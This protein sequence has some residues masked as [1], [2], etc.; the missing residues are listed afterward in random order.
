MAAAHLFDPNAAARAF[1]Q[2][3]TPIRG[4]LPVSFF[5]ALLPLIAVLLV[6]GGLR[7]PSWQAALAGLVV[8]L[9]I[10]IGVW[11]FPP[12][13]ALAAVANGAM[14]AIWPLLWVVFNAILLY[15]VTVKS[16]S[17][18]ALKEWVIDHLPDDRRIVLVVVGFCFGALLE[19]IAGFG[20]PVAITS[21]LLILA[22]FAPLEAIVC[23]LIFN[24][25]PV[26]F[27]ALGVPITVLAA[28][29]HL[30]PSSL[31]A[32]VG[33]QLPLFALILPFYGVGVYAGRR[34]IRVLWPVLLVAGGTFGLAQ[35]ACANFISY[36]LTDVLASLTSLVA[37]VAF[38]RYWRPAVDPEFAMRGAAAKRRGDPMPSAWRAWA[39]WIV[40][41][42]T[43]IVWTSLGLSGLGEAKIPWPGLHERVAITLY[44]G[45]LYPALWHF[46]P[47][48]TGT[49][50]LVSTLA[51]IT[52]VKLPPAHLLECA[53][54]TL[55]QTRSTMVTVMLMLALAYLMNYSGLNYT[56]GL[57]V[58]SLGVM[59][60]VLS[61]F[62]GWL[63]V[64]LSGTDAAG[65]AL[66]GNLQVI[67]ARQL[68]LDP[69]LF[70]ATNSSGGVMGKMI[71]PQNIATGC[72]V[73]KFCSDEGEVFARTFRHSVVL[74]AA[75]GALV[76]V[77]AFLIPWIVPHSSVQ[78][79]PEAHGERQRVPA[80]LLDV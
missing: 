6:L 8:G 63:A 56:I 65:N 9:L 58:S 28:V 2:L 80:R 62:L 23:T 57:G 61:P 34:S 78:H 16:G 42:A 49:A 11:Q 15:N 66:F 10:A 3:L 14:F 54:Q 29:T 64:T 48:G 30:P 76:A 72:S 75:L 32:M 74:T 52:I 35:F 47:L 43:V 27:S 24:T 17:F 21:S 55:S 51:T 4:S 53:V 45:A 68:G 36:G 22:G 13:L 1:P 69:V 20:T 70:A 46:Q 39:P 33:R 41:S 40:V 38:L 37:T 19:G 67:A 7:R 73:T 50:I 26:A 44:K 5:V 79:Q 31:A 60:V 77:Q 12:S 59:F 71:S 25:A 18:D